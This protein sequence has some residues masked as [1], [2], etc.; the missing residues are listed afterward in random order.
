MERA[1]PKPR[2]VIRVPGLVP[3]CRYQHTCA[4]CPSQGSILLEYPAHGLLILSNGHSSRQAKSLFVVSHQGTVT[5]SGTCFSKKQDGN[6]ELG[7]FSSYSYRARTFPIRLLSGSSWK[8]D[9]C[10]K[11][12]HST[13]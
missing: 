10:Q 8:M 11:K 9:I 2:L 5:Q 4:A 1:L 12:Q 3:G 6:A 7:N 13:C